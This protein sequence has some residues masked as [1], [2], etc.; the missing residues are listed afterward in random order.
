MQPIPSSLICAVQSCS[1]VKDIIIESQSLWS[2]KDVG[3]KID[4]EIKTQSANTTTDFFPFKFVNMRRAINTEADFHTLS[5]MDYRF[6]PGLD[7]FDTPRLNMLHLNNCAN[8]G[9]L[10]NSLL[11]NLSQIRITGLSLSQDKIKPSTGYLGKEKIE[12]FLMVYRGLET[13]A[14]S[15]LG[16]NRPC[17]G[18]ILAQGP[19]LKF[20]DLCEMSTKEDYTADQPLTVASDSD[21]DRIRR[22]CPHLHHLS[23]RPATEA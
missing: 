18:A 14:L 2:T 10:F 3:V 16:E 9:Y 21:M 23:V 6:P 15:N 20:L 5:F 13:L 17:L 11:C 12:C 19:T 7:H 8:V 1:N 22:A 4:A